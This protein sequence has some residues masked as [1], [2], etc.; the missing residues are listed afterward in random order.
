[1]VYSSSTFF[2]AFTGGLLPAVVWLWFWLREDRLSPEPRGL[3]VATF[4]AGMVATLAAL[5]IENWLGAY[6]PMPASSGF[7][8]SGSLISVILWAGTEEISK[9][10]LGGGDTPLLNVLQTNPELLL[11][12]PYL[13]TGC[14]FILGAVGLWRGRKELTRPMFLI[15]V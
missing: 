15:I 6:F 5:L 14:F 10:V 4:C 12:L 9:F 3:V 1:M 2:F 11:R 13:A 7:V 8:L